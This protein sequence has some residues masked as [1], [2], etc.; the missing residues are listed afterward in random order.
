MP[1][2]R[3]HSE[4][5]GVLG[6]DVEVCKKVDGDIDEIFHDYGRRKPK[7][8]SIF[9]RIFN[10]SLWLSRLERNEKVKLYFTLRLRNPEYS[11][12]F[13]LH[14]V[15]DLLAGLLIAEN[16]TGYSRSI[17]YKAL[18][19]KAYLRDVTIIDRRLLD[20]IVESVM[21]K[22]VN[23]VSL[24]EWCREESEEERRRRLSKFNLCREGKPPIEYR[25]ESYKAAHKTVGLPEELLKEKMEAEAIKWKH[26]SEIKEAIKTI[27]DKNCIKEWILLTRD[28]AL[29]TTRINL[30]AHI[31]NAYSEIYKAARRAFNHLKLDK[32]AA[33]HT[34]LKTLSIYD[35]PINV[36]KNLAEHLY[37]M[38][39]NL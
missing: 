31:N 17:E 23:N 1:S 19:L 10:P 20:E 4:C 26:G 35:I 36:S 37:R 11:R 12:C 38:I 33:K 34:L 16:L 24:R 18:F 25:L 14:H 9:E 22:C 29:Q 30:P 8:G 21:E 6:F 32:E 3:V 13:I 27:L 2:W 15:L 28:K 5:A 7:A 39:E